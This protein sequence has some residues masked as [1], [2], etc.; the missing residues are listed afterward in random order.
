MADAPAPF[1]LVWSPGGDRP[2]RFKHSS[3]RS[4]S[5]E[6]DRLAA[7]NP[8]SKFYV[9]APVCSTVAQLMVRET[10]CAPFDDVPF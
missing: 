9:L 6:A 8:G 2:P 10:F 5:V 7:A 1:W 3:L 4:A